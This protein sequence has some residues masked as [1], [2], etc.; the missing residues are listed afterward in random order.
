[1]DELVI[2]GHDILEFEWGGDVFELAGD[3][4]V[5]LSGDGG[6]NA[7]T[8]G[9]QNSAYHLNRTHHTGDQAQ[10]TVTGL[11]TKLA[12]LDQTD[13]DQQAQIDLKLDAADYNDRY[14]GLF[15][16]YYELELAWPT[17]SAGD[18]A[19]VDW[20]LG[21]DVV[22]YAW[23][24][25]DQYWAAIGVSSISDT[26]ALP[27][28]TNNLYFT[29]QRVRD[30]ALSGL[31]LLSSLAITAAD[32]VLSAF[33]KLQAQ[34]SALSNVA[35]TGSYND[36]SDKPNVDTSKSLV[37]ISTS[38]KIITSNISST[39]YSADKITFNADLFLSLALYDTYAIEID[40]ILDFPSAQP[41][42]IGIMPFINQA[43][44]PFSSEMQMAV[45]A[46]NSVS[47]YKIRLDLTRVSNNRMSVSGY[48]H[49]LNGA[50]VTF[51]HI[52]GI[53]SNTF[54][55]NVA[56]RFTGTPQGQNKIIVKSARMYKLANPT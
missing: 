53:Y 38:N 50:I 23:D 33:G 26:D 21:T 39:I 34:I 42:A 30:T 6:G 17:A 49:G 1:M 19:Q 45:N 11:V 8:L 10:S 31:S 27:E 55:F 28:G 51:T 22:E 4:T 12:N 13:I 54:M 24:V 15:T 3:A 35:R 16:S 47:V 40:L 14:K 5:F 41:N 48:G 46:V 52:S 20:G 32:S 36:L 7:D 29:S 43:A 56:A 18:K 37:A 9:G 44:I 25:S 2:D